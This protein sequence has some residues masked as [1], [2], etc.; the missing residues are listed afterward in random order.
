MFYNVRVRLKFLKIMQDN[1]MSDNS[2][3]LADFIH[4]HGIRGYGPMAKKLGFDIKTGTY[5]CIWKSLER[6]DMAKRDNAVGPGLKALDKIGTKPGSI[7]NLE[8]YE[9]LLSAIAIEYEELPED[10]K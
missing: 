1:G 8:A 2:T 7:T 3:G 10:W 9:R 6:W 4:V 5:F